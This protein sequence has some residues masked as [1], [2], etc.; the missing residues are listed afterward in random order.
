[1]A[2]AQITTPEGIKISIDGTSK[3]ISALIE[4]LKEK[5]A[6]EGPKRQRRGAKPGRVLLGDLIAS[7]KDGGFFKKPKDLASVKS[8]LEEMGHHYPVTT[9]SPVMLRRV[10]G[11]DLRRIREKGRWLYTG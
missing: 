4:D 9:L 8:A 2:K 10:R 5:A 3:E 7:L 11:R 6:E 1:M